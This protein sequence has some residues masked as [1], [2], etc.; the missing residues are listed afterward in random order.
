[1]KKTTFSKSSLQTL[2]K[3]GLVSLVVHVN[4]QKEMRCELY[5]DV[6]TLSSEIACF[7]PYTARREKDGAVCL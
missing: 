3:I 4:T 1:M 5:S 6:S 2:A 7:N